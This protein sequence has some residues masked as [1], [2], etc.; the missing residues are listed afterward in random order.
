MEGDH[1]FLSFDFVLTKGPSFWVISCLGPFVQLL[2]KL[3][4]LLCLNAKLVLLY[5][6]LKKE[7]QFGL[8]LEKVQGILE[9]CAK[10]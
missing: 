2:V 10:I 6:L 5:R 4:L 7:A 9:V 1:F 3:P 8:S